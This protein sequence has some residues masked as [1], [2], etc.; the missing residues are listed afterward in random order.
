MQQGQH[1]RK[2]RVG[3]AK[4]ANIEEEAHARKVMRSLQ[5]YKD[6]AEVAFSCLEEAERRTATAAATPDL[7]IIPSPDPAATQDVSGDV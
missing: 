2:L 7:N 6:I 1:K 5:V 3:Y 4:A